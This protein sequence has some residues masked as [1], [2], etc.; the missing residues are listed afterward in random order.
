M[1]STCSVHVEENEAVVRDALKNI[2]HMFQIEHALPSWD[3]RGM[4]KCDETDNIIG[5]H[6]VRADAKEDLTNGFFIALFVRRD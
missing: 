6:C 3:R 4:D 1:Y 5:T 2:G